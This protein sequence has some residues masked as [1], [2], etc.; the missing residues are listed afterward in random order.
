MKAEEMKTS[1]SWGMIG[2]YKIQS[3]NGGQELFGSCVKN[4]SSIRIVV[5]QAKRY[6]SLGETHYMG[7]HSLIEIEMTNLQFAEFMT[8]MN[9]GDGVPCTIRYTTESGGYIPF[10]Q[11][12]SVLETI[13]QDREKRI[14]EAETAV[15]DAIG[16]IE[17]LVK[18]KKISKTTY[19]ILLNSMRKVQSIDSNFYRDQAQR[20]INKM[21]THAKNELNTFLEQKSTSLG[22]DQNTQEILK[23]K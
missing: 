21:V 12:E 2:G 3:G 4:N 18:S 6:R 10:E 5:K 15:K 14:N 11:E 17:E 20:E 22:I 7:G 1:K 23:L 13:E 8:N 19:D 16:T 9:V